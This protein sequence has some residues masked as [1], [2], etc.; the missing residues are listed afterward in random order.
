[1]L[2]PTDD[3]HVTVTPISEDGTQASNFESVIDIALCPSETT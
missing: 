3:T 2:S 1:M